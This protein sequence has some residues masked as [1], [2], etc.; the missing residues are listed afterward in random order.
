M[1]M[2][3]VLQGILRSI[4]RW[5][6][7]VTSDVGQSEI[8]PPQ[9]V[10]V[11]FAGQLSFEYETALDQIL[12]LGLWRGASASNNHKILCRRFG[13]VSGKTETLEAIGTDLGITRERVRQIQQKALI[14]I[15]RS[16][17]SMELPRS[18]IC[19]VKQ[20]IDGKGGAIAKEDVLKLVGD[21]A[22]T[23]RYNRDMGVAFILFFSPFA[24]DLPNSAEDRWIVYDSDA[25]R[26]RFEMASHCIQAH[27]RANGPSQRDHL[28]SS[29]AGNG[30]EA[31]AVR[32][33]LVINAVT[34]KIEDH[35]WLANPPKWH[36]VLTGLRRLGQP[37]H[38]SEIAA[39]VNSQLDAGHGMTE[40][41]VH[42]ALAAKEP[43]VF[44][45]VGLGTFGLAEWG[46]P[47]AKDSVDLVCQILEGEL[48][49]L[50]FQEITIKARAFGWQAKPQSIKMALHLEAQK[51]RRRVRSIGSNTFARYGL[52]WWNDP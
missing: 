51:S 35:V 16:I 40:R 22:P 9:H 28:I 50:T 5:P 39:Q 24:I 47:V 31:D 41:A 23:L 32:T 2:A 25:Q 12:S 6:T 42:A 8:T 3:K 1:G 45:R 19:L 14:H 37:A 13:L 30:I 11:Q 52:S 49:W 27:L 46:L 10:E 18:F 48:N 38:F 43:R 7:R 20:E 17:H 21:R 26:S 33:S 44:R 4:R 15:R 29:L 34:T 36:F